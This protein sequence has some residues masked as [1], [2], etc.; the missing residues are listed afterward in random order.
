MIDSRRATEKNEMHEVGIDWDKSQK[1]YALMK[2][3]K[4]KSY[5]MNVKC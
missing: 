2:F 5:I 3:T 4:F 1:H